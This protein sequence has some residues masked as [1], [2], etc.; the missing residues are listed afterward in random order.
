MLNVTAACNCL[1]SV[2]ASFPPVLNSARCSD[3][4]DLVCGSC[5]CPVGWSGEFCECRSTEISEIPADQTSLDAAMLAKCTR[6][7][8]KDVGVL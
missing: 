5:E 8:D 1:A 2:C 6:P 7:G 3:L 4:G